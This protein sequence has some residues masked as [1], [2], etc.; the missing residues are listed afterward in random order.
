MIPSEGADSPEEDGHE[1]SDAAL[2]EGQLLFQD[3]PGIAKDESKYQGGAL[4]WRGQKQ[5]FE[6]N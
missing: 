6:S 1:K 4:G 2:V 5:A 3:D